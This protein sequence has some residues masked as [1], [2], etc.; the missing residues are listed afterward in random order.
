[1][2]ALRTVALSDISFVLVWTEIVRPMFARETR[3]SPRKSQG[4]MFGSL[5]KPGFPN[6]ARAAITRYN[7]GA[8]ANMTKSAF[9]LLTIFALFGNLG[10][11]A[12]AT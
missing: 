6:V 11:F 7:P 1:M 2:H 5:A 12:K 10:S 9:A 4:M 3:A 8:A